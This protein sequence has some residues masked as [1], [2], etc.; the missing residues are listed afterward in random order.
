MLVNRGFVRFV[1]TAAAVRPFEE[2][3]GPKSY[4]LIGCLHEYVITKKYS[5]DRLHKSGM[6]RYKEYGKIVK[7]EIV[8]GTT[9]V[10]L[11]DP[12][13]IKKMYQLE[14]KYPDR[15]SH[16]A[17][18]HLRLKC[19]QSYNNGGLLPT[20]GPQWHRI[21][22]LAQKPLSIASPIITASAME[23][24]A[25]DFVRML[26]EKSEQGCDLQQ[27]DFLEELKKY[28]LEVTGVFALGVRLGAIKAD[29][30]PESEASRLM[31]AALETNSNILSTDNSFGGTVW[32]PRT[33][34][35]YEEARNTLSVSHRNMWMRGQN[36]KI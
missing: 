22:S 33:T 13:D 28:F 26:E 30:S 17:L 14:G 4:P 21:R 24:V 10:Y 8:P 36:L 35:Q 29:L 11:F 34:L 16:L 12:K 25:R 27:I 6:S 1:T 15:R 20:N 23:R 31:E 9:L 18:E 2:I 7:E 19:P 5:L 3:P 32:R